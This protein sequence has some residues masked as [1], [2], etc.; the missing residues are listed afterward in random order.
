MKKISVTVNGVTRPFTGNPDMPLLWLSARCLAP[1]RSRIR[2]TEAPQ[3][4]HVHLVPSEDLPTGVCEP[5]V[6]PIAP[7]ICN[8]LFAITGTRIRELPVSKARFT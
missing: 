4:T 8:A 5:G 2:L 1:D 6:P 3:V 7:A